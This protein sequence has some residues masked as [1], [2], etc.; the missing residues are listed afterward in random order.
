MDN[1]PL[2]SVII[3]TRNRLQLL[4]KALQ[5]VYDQTYKNLEVIVVDDQSGDG[6]RSFLQSEKDA[7]KLWFIRNESPAGA[8]K[9][10]NLGI[11]QASGT[12]VSFL[13]DDDEW[14]PEKI[15]R[16]VAVFNQY[17]DVGMVYTGVELVK[18]DYDIT[19][20]SIP[21]ISGHIFKELLIENRI[22]ATITVAIRTEIARELLFDEAFPAREEYDLWLRIARTHEIWGIKKPLARN[23]SR[24]TLA[25]ISSDVQNYEKA[26]QLLNEKYKRDVLALTPAE[27]QKR[28][29][30]QSFFLASQ[31]LMAGNL[32][33]ARKYFFKSM[34]Q[35]PQLRSFSGFVASFLGT[36]TLF[37][38]RKLRK[39]D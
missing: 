23:Y 26:I 33:L 22:G 31:A 13:D 37:R 24:N 2:V 25:R 29:A 10:R 21:A 12:I 1:N 35:K 28:L 4:K 3:P 34:R 7:G 30:A 6:T 9:A 15:E 19:Y 11:K 18:V 38:L 36:K 32:R 27:Q 8:G 16:Q 39:P 5:S 14:L 20:H 17:P